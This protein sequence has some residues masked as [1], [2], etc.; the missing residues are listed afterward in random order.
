[1]RIFHGTIEIAGQMGILSS[2][3]TKKGHCS[4]GYNTFHSYLGYKDFLI[5]TNQGGLEERVQE[6]LEEYDLFHFHYG[7]TLLPEFA[8]LPEIKSQHKKMI[9]H[10]WGNDVRFHDQARKNNP[11]VYTGDSPSNEDI[12]AK[13]MKITEHIKEAIVQDYEVYDYVKDYYEKVHVVPIAIDLTH[14]QPH[15][16]SVHKDRPLILHAPT[17]PDFKGTFYIEKTIER[18]KEDYD[19]EYR[20]IEKM[21]HEEV[22]KLYKD[23]D[24]IIDQVLCGSYGLLSVE[25]MALGKPVLTFIRPDLIS[26]FP[27]ELPIVNANP[28]NLY[29]Q[30]KR[31]LDN[32]DLRRDLGVSGRQYV[33]K[34]HSHE[35]IADRLLAIY[36]TLRG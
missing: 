18:L 19:F 13:L 10:H 29:E 9:M 16:P 20:R 32:P 12:H 33:E 4:V 7:S 22:I 24:I 3:L 26:S 35:I 11:Y 21:N 34:V 27:A 28:D 15:Y 25:S 1:M 23:A 14:F 36:A 2:A 5:N 17:N 8:D 31:L 6:I 30:V